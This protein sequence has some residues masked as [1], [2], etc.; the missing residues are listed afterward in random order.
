[1]QVPPVHYLDATNEEEAATPLKLLLIFSFVNLGKDAVLQA[2]RLLGP[3]ELQL[4]QVKGLVKV[5]VYKFTI[6]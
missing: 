2:M 5:R 6:I 1:V 4:S 3:G